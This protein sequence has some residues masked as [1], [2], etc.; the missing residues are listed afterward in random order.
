MDLSADRHRFDAGS[1]VFTEKRAFA[2]DGINFIILLES[3]HTQDTISGYSITISRDAEATI[4]YIDV[5]FS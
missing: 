2:V 1:A 4:P 3:I 5:T